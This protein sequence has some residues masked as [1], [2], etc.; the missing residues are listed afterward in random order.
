MKPIFFVIALILCIP[1]LALSQHKDTLI[2]KDT[3]GNVVTSTKVK[4]SNWVYKYD[5]T[6]K[7]VYEPRKA[8][9]LSAVVPGLG[10]AYNKKYWKIPLA[11]AAVGIPIYS[12]FYNRGIYR[13]IQYAIT[14]AELDKNDPGYQAAYDQVDPKLQYLVDHQSIN[15][16]TNYRNEYRKDMDYSILFT[17]LLWGLNVVDA[18]VDAHLKGFNVNDN[19]TMQIKPAITSPQSI[20]I[21][22]V[23]K[24]ADR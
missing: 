8:A 20:G 2:V 10:Q 15:S 21:A 4:K 7:R 17:L 11:W 24:F 9:I 3:A 18:T 14:V 5:S 1:M 12:Y 23:F 16:L 13:D 22:L 6:G 19:L